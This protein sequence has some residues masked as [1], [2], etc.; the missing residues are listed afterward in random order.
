MIGGLR[1][2]PYSEGR[3]AC[4]TVAGRFS[5]SIVS[6]HGTLLW[7]QRSEPATPGCPKALERAA[8]TSSQVT[9]Q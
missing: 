6:K 5:T 9:R 7:R 2:K 4:I 8:K 3:G 1:L